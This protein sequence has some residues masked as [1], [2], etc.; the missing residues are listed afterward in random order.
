MNKFHIFKCLNL[1]AKL[2]K[3]RQ[4]PKATFER[5]YKTL[6]RRYKGRKQKEHPFITK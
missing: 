3:I 5:K 2:G 1:E 4:K 6:S